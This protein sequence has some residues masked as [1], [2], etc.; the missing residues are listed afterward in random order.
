MTTAGGPPRTIL[1]TLRRENHGCIAA[2]KDVQNLK[3]SARESAL[4]GRLP[5]EALLDLLETNKL[6][7]R[8]PKVAD[9]KLLSLFIT[10]TSSIS[11]TQ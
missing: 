10:P 2:R 9:G 3:Q 6:F 1:S 7:H 8:V 11:L 5:I 4:N